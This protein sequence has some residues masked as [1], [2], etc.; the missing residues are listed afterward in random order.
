MKQLLLSC[1]F[2]FLG[3]VIGLGGAYAYFA[4]LP[5][6]EQVAR[7][8]EAAPPTDAEVLENRIAQ[9]QT[10]VRAERQRAEAAV[11]AL[12]QARL[13]IVELT[14][15]GDP[16]EEATPERGLSAR[17]G[18][19]VRQQ[20]EQQAFTLKRRLGLDDATAAQVDDLLAAHAEDRLAQVRARFSGEAAPPPRETTLRDDL[21]ALLSDE[22][23][24]EYD[25]IMETQ[26]QGQLETMA[27]A[28]LAQLSTSLDLDEAQKDA[29]YGALYRDSERGM[30]TNRGEPTN[31]APEAP[32]LS[33][34][35]QSILT[36]DQF[37]TWQTNQEGQDNSMIF[38]RG[39]RGG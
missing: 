13:E 29:V 24:A 34:E 39:G 18:E 30:A 25:A 15:D 1:F 33:G 20:A 27:S 38:L 37:E 11:R 5:G 7:E 4:S 8:V 9:L 12:T 2:F 3:I 36:P 10:A 32:S 35:L 6:P 16:D 28:Q 14:E 19:R 23:L 17:I 21:A 31:E 26:R 22:Q